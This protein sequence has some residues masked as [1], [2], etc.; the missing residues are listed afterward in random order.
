MERKRKHPSR[1][2]STPAHTR[3]QIRILLYIFEYV[4]SEKWSIPRS[5]AQRKPQSFHA[6]F[7]HLYDK[8]E[9]PFIL[10]MKGGS[11]DSSKKCLR[12]TKMLLIFK[13]DVKMMIAFWSLMF[14]FPLMFVCIPRR[15]PRRSLLIK[16]NEMWNAD[17]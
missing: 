16:Q 6:F 7:C 12:M 15:Y 13:A 8:Q 5:P 3:E 9:I 14:C 4:I 11:L 2:I 10:R 1:L 17:D